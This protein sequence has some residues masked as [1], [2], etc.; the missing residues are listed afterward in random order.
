MNRTGQI[1]VSLDYQT[2]NIAYGSTNPWIGMEITVTYSDSTQGWYDAAGS[3]TGTPPRIPTGSSNGWVRT[4]STYALKAGVTVT[5]V[6]CNILVRDCTGTVEMRNFKVETGSQATPWCAAYEESTIDQTDSTLYGR[7]LLRNTSNY[8]NTSYWNTNTADVTITTNASHNL[9]IK[10][11]AAVDAI[12][13]WTPITIPVVAG[14]KYTLTVTGR[15]NGWDGTSGRWSAFAL[16]DSGGSAF[17]DQ[18]VILGGLPTNGTIGTVRGTLVA[19]NS[20]TQTIA[21]STTSVQNNLEL[22]IQSIKLEALGYATD[23]SPA[24]EDNA[25]SYPNNAA[26]FNKWTFRYYT[27]GNNGTNKIYTY[28]DFPSL[29]PTY[30]TL[31]TDQANVQQNVGDYYVGY[32]KTA[33]YVSTAKTVN[34]ATCV[35]DTLTVYVNGLQQFSHS[36]S[37]AGV[38]MTIP[39]SLQSGWNTVELINQEVA[40]GD[41]IWN[42]PVLSSLVDEMNANYALDFGPLK[43]N[44]GVLGYN[45]GSMTVNTSAVTDTDMFMCVVTYRGNTY[46]DSVTIDDVTDPIGVII[47]GMDMFK[48][49]QGTNTYTATLWQ[50]G[51]QIDPSGTIYTYQ[52]YVYNSDGSLDASFGGTGSKTGQTITVDHTDI[53]NNGSLVCQVYK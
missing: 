12:H 18:F 25:T 21:I 40:G 35:D 37:S 7:N 44:Y 39:L 28:S 22:E 6:A 43:G 15:I 48:N 4:S 19:S 46:K 42:T 38:A 2:T 26:G 52:W 11:I 30:Q 45:T 13:T 23:Y 53:T 49:G 32:Y 20:G 33:V 24:P 17:Y 9:S 47:N 10:K 36:G 51:V 16:A 1:A 29:T 3:Q 14:Q 5:A 41:G 27:D 31:L 34:F 50:N 8:S